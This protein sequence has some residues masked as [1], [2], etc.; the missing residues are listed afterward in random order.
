MI[1]QFTKRDW[2]RFTFMNSQLINTQFMKK[3]FIISELAKDVLVKEVFVKD[4]LVD[5]FL[6]SVML[7]KIVDCIDDWLKST[8]YICCLFEDVSYVIPYAYME[9]EWYLLC[10]RWSFLL[11]FIKSVL[12]GSLIEPVGVIILDFFIAM[13]SNPSSVDL[14]GD[15]CFIKIRLINLLF[16]NLV[17]LNVAIIRMLGEIRFN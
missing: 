1:W 9:F 15:G 14:G 8:Q 13:C 10:R 6:S 12:S 17:F 5:L 4:V 16:V 3:H 11:Y 7:L 2:Y